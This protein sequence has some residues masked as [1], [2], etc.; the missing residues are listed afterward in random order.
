MRTLRWL[1]VLPGAIAALVIG[2]LAG[3]IVGSVFGQA[4]A[5]TGS[6]F[7]AMFAFVFAACMISPAHRR[8]VGPVSAAVVVLLALGTV[9]LSNFTTLEEFS[10]LSTRERFVTPVAQILGALYALFI[11]LPVLTPGTTLE[12]LWREIVALGSVVG[13][14]GVLIALFGAGAGLA[15]LGWL[16]FKVG[17]SVMVLG[18]ATWL[19]P[20]VLAT[21][22]ARKA[23]TLLQ[24]RFG[25]IL[26]H[27]NSIG[28]EAIVPE[29]GRDISWS[30]IVRHVFRVC[31]FDRSG[32]TIGPDGQV[33]PVSEV[34]PYGHLLVES[35]I[36]NQRARLPIIHRDDFIL[37]A[38]VFDDP[39]VAGRLS[40]ED[41]LVT[42]APKHHRHDGRSGSPHHVLHYVLT[43][44][45]ALY[46]YY[47]VDDDAHMRSP[48]PEKLFGP[49]VYEGIISVGVNPEPRL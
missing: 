31:E 23:R 16:G 1:L 7:A 39:R 47:A 24:E 41:L 40:Q 38:S 36:L 29:I 10:S 26:N 6:A 18:A 9:I 43:P 44:R 5:D 15:G 28:V 17:L 32:T 35:P 30:D 49:F 13:T 8:R 3:G 48:K 46:R 45:G 42:Y 27:E 11:S 33:Y 34:S 21:A 37:A 19:L 14:L 25:E 12:R 4:A 20:F 22:R 2:S